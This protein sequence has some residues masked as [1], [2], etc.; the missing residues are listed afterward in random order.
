VNSDI[1]VDYDATNCG[2]MATGGGY[3]SQEGAGRF[4]LEF[5][6]CTDNISTTIEKKSRR[7]DVG[8]R[9]LI[10]IPESFYYS[11]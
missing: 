2:A 4:S 3:L 11:E 10:E 8:F 6:P 1:I 5:L 9:C 7:T